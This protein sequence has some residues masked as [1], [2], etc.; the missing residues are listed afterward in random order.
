M[1]TDVEDTEFIWKAVGAPWGPVIAFASPIS[2]LPRVS[3]SRRD[4]GQ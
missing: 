4:S 3:E 2:L 1:L